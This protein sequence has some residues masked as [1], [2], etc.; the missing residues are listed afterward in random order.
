MANFVY[1]AAATRILNGGVDLLTDTLKFMLVDAAY[2]ADRDDE[3]VS[4][5]SAAEIN[6]TNYTGGFGG[7]GRKTLTGKAVNKDNTNDRAEFDT[8]DPTW[9]ALGGATN[10]TIQAVLV[11][12]EN[13]SDADSWLIAHIDTSTGTPSL[14]FTTNGGDLTL[15]INVEGLIQLATV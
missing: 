4:A 8:N 12:R 2:T 7:A 3:F 11:I 15:N 1:N 14:P 13:T 9:T 6:A 5:A 10:D